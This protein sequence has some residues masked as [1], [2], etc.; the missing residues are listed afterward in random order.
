L[1]KYSKKD[2]LHRG[3]Y[4]QEENLVGVM[5]PDG[6]LAKIMFETSPAWQTP[7]EMAELLEWTHESL[8][9]KRFHPLLVIANFIVE[10]LRIHP[11]K[12]G[13]GRL[14]RILTNLLLL[15][16]GYQFMQYVSHE[17]IVEHRKDEYYLALRKSQETFKTDHET[18]SPWLN[19]FLLVIKEQASKALTY[20]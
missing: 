16:S 13:N 9:Q 3:R 15:R 11:F 18:I 6:K 10:F 1:L 2:E 5:A 17:Q 20:L 4:K 7:A 12:D 19:F 14:S 8:E